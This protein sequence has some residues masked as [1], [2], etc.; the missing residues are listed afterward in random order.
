MPNILETKGEKTGNNK[1]NSQDLSHLNSPTLQSMLHFAHR[2][3]APETDTLLSQKR[4]SARKKHYP[5]KRAL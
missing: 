2:A 4:V 3:L 1:E 5:D